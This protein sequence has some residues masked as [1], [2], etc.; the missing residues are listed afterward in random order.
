MKVLHFNQSDIGGGAGIAGYRLHNALMDRGIESH[1]LVAPGNKKTGSDLVTA[2]PPPGLPEKIRYRIGSRFGLHYLHI[3]S[4]FG[5]TNNAL[6]QESDVLNFHNIH[7]G[8]FNYLAIP[9]LTQDKPAIFT[10][11]DMWSFTGHCAYSYD[12]DR[13]KTGCGQ[14]PYPEVYPAVFYDNTAIEWK[15]KKWVYGHSN[16]TIVAPSRWLIAQ[17]QQSMLSHFPIHHIPSGID[18]DAFQPLDSEQCRNLLGIPSGKKVLMFGA[19]SFSDARKGGDILCQALA[20]LPLALKQDLVLLTIGNHREPIEELLGIQT[21]SLGFMTS[22]RLR[23]IAYSAADLLLCPTRADNLPL[24]L[25]ESMS[26]GTPMVS[27]KVGGVPDFVRPGETGYL[28]EPENTEDFR[29]GIMELLENDILRQQMAKNCRE[30]TLNEY[31]L[32]IQAQRYID[33]YNIALK[34][35]QH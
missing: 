4:T 32:E 2:L 20:D 1:I 6:Y 19:E 22:D 34:P 9:K 26:C 8:Y 27:F 5:L 15:L 12:C 35:Q 3:L 30:I 7:Q 14:C 28:A 24:I 31:T 11:H 16:L 25:Q 29:Q 21:I 33:L 13:W 18:T 23:C 17:V 10:L